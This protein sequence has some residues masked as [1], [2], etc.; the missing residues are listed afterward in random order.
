MKRFYGYRL[1]EYLGNVYH[2][3]VAGEPDINDVEEFS[4]TVHYFDEEREEQIQIA[5][6]DTRHGGVHFDK[7]YRRDQP[8]EFLDIEH[9]WEAEEKLRE[10]WRTYAKNHPETERFDGSETSR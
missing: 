3:T 7:L 8:R 10:N 5:R 9:Y 2:L 4:V 1:G 6:I